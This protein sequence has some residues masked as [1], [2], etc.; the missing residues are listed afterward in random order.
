MGLLVFFFACVLCNRCCGSETIYSGSGFSF[1]F[2]EFRI[3]AKVPDPC[4]SGSVSNLY[5]L[6]IFRNCK[7]THLKFNHK[8]ESINYLRFSISYYTQYTQSRIQREVIFL[9]ICSFIFCRIRI[10]N[11]GLLYIVS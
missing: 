9:F 7:K 2:S 5:Y 3:R 4:G 11:T 10:H 6:S 1:E 8:E